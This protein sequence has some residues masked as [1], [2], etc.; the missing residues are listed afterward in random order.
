M[1]NDMSFKIKNYLSYRQSK[2][3]RLKQKE[4]NKNNNEDIKEKFK[5]FGI[6]DNYPNNKFIQ[7]YN[8]KTDFFNLTLTDRINQ[9]NS[10]SIYSIND[11]QI[12]NNE[13]NIKEDNNKLFLEINQLKKEINLYQSRLNELTNE[14]N[15][16]NQEYQEN[17]I[18]NCTFEEINKEKDIEKE[19]IKLEEEKYSIKLKQVKNKNDLLKKRNEKMIKHNQQMK[20]FYKI[21]MGEE[22]VNHEKDK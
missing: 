16:L 1:K 6:N 13:E 17:L 12:N 14:Y 18:K 3:N 15:K 11:F 8:N 19:F 7:L 5:K 10:F 22:W 21:Y 2:K 20:N 4:L 9:G